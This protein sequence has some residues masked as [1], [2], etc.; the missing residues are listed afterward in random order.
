MINLEA[1][2]YGVLCEF[3][4]QNPEKGSNSL[5]SQDSYKCRL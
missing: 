3:L 5:K 1:Y 2:S 4:Q